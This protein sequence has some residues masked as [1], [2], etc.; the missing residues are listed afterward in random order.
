M[1]HFSKLFAV[2]C[3]VLSLVLSSNAV[4]GASVINPCNQLKVI[5]CA[6]CEK[7]IRL[8]EKLCDKNCRIDELIKMVRGYCITEPVIVCAQ[9]AVNPTESVTVPVKPTEPVT[10]PT[11]PVIKPAEPVTAPTQPVI[12]PAEP[13]TAP[14]QPAIKP[15]E[16][17]TVPTQQTVEPTQPVTSEFNTT[18]EAEV[19][20]LVNEQRVKYGLSLLAADNGAE[21]VA[22]LRAK[23]I[24]KSFSHTRPNGSSCFTAAKEL[25][26]S[27]RSAGENIA[28]GYPNPESVVNGWMNSEGHRKNIL[29]PSFGRI[30]IGCYKSGGVLYWTQFFID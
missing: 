30:G 22:H 21:E 16:P 24:V 15:A 4:A 17:V 10:V 26:V 3:A 20:R 25:G 28:Y 27:Y 19:L 6:D 9:P 14:T 18:Y 29:S 23:E 8:I 7:N 13:V 11:Q 5:Q 1:K 2:I 12:K